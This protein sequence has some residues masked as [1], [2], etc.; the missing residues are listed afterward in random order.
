MQPDARVFAGGAQQL[1][2]PLDTFNLGRFGRTLPPDPRFQQFI[3]NVFA[4]LT[5]PAPPAE[6]KL[7]VRRRTVRVT[8]RTLP[9]PRVR[10]ILIV[11]HR[12]SLAFQIGDAGVVRVCP[13]SKGVCMQRRLSRGTYRWAAVTVDEWGESVP[14]YSRAVVIRA[15]G[16]R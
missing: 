3:R 6:V 13:S 14:T 5:R 11:R 12:G 1:S 9:D 8:V 15:R 4:D 16:G 7:R 10:Q 2:W